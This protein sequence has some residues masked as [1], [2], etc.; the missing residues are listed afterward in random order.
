[1][2]AHDVIQTGDNRAVCR[3]GE[4]F[5]GT[6]YDKARIDHV[7]HAL[8]HRHDAPPPADDDGVPF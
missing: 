6:T 2:T 3:C 4:V 1:M 7:R 8:A 5:T